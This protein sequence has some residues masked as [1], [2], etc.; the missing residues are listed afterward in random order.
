M[1][2]RER[3]IELLTFGRPDRFAFHHSYGLM[4]G[5][6]ERWHAEGLPCGVTEDA[7]HEHFGFDR[8][9][10]PLPVD[11]G[12]LPPF[13]PSETQGADGL[14]IQRDA[15]GVGRRL[16]RGLTTLG[17]PFEFPVR[18]PDEWADYKWRLQYSP[19]RIGRDLEA[20]HEESMH[21]GQPARVACTGLYWFPRDLMGDQALCLSY[22]TQP[23]LV[24]DILSTY[25]DM[26]LAVSEE[27]LGR[28]RVDWLH[29]AEDMCWRKGMMV[30][31]ATFREFMMPHYRRLIGLY[32]ARGARVFCVDSDG[33]LGQLIPLLIEAGAN[34][35]T[36]CEVMAGNDVVALRREH[37]HRVAFIGGLNKL[38][39]ADEPVSLVPGAGRGRLT[40]QEAIEEELAYRLPP[41]RA[42]GG[43][44]PALDHRVVPQSSLESFTYYVRRVRQMLG[45]ALEAPAFCR[46]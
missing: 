19:E 35:V 8:E 15:L 7:V 44:V 34:V 33:H 18:G 22:Y 1:T 3:I 30:S 46:G 24:R 36:P 25:S 20:R 13:E 28:V 12:L 21:A 16:R 27:L 40:P 29:M 9:P 31:P 5:T 17:I 39:L 23:A 2:H 26:V 38:A 6:L 42:S 11:F 4:P 41:M 45:L 37:G 43:Y 32:R 14:V 10:A